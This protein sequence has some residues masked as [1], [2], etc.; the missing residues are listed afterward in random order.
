LIAEL[1]FDPVLW[2]VTELLWEYMPRTRAIA[3]SALAGAIWRVRESLSCDVAMLVA[4]R[5]A[6]PA[7]EGRLGFT[8]AVDVWRD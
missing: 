5:D 7:L 6:K 1:R 8:W 4:R 2:P 3:Y